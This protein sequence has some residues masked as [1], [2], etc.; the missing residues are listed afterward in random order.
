MSVR[1]AFSA[2]VCVNVS[3]ANP[4]LKIADTTN[5]PALRGETF[6]LCHIV[7][8]SAQDVTGFTCQMT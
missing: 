1:I 8:L 4:R 3:I 6:Q 2:F 5:I 7:S